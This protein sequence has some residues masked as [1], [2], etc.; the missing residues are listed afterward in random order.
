MRETPREFERRT[1]Q[2]MPA[3][4]VRIAGE[5]LGSH[6]RPLAEDEVCPTLYRDV[7]PHALHAFLQGKLATLEGPDSLCIFMRDATLPGFSTVVR[8]MGMLTV[9]E[10]LA[11]GPWFSG[12]SGIYVAERG[13]MPRAIGFVPQVESIAEVD[14]KLEQV[15]DTETL[16][17]ALGGVRYDE[18]VREAKNA[19]QQ[20]LELWSQVEAQASAWR[21]LVGGHREALRTAALT[22][23][24]REGVSENDLSVPLFSLPRARRSELAQKLAALAVAR[25]AIAP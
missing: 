4:D 22:A 18:Q 12:Q 3:T 2:P 20:Y 11:M 13:L 10:P 6:A 21:T 25:A 14:A 23:L 16:R 19:V 24:E 15:S 5:L 17:E 1:G 8:E 9:L 7:G